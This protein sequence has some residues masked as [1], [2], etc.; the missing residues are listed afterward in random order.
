MSRRSVRDV[1]K[2][3]VFTFKRL[4]PPPRAHAHK[5]TGAELDHTSEEEDDDTENIDLSFMQPKAA[6]TSK[7]KKAGAGAGNDLIGK[8]QMDFAMICSNKQIYL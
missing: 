5:T 4:S 3:E 8:Q 2:P 1:K 7:A 6:K